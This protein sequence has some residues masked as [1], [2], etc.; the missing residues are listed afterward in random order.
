M[1]FYLIESEI[2]SIFLCISIEII[3]E[4]FEVA[5]DDGILY[6]GTC[7]PQYVENYKSILYSQYG[8]VQ[9]RRGF[10]FCTHAIAYTKWRA[11]RFWNDL[12]TSKLLHNEVGSD[13][14]SRAWQM[15]TKTYPFSVASNIQ[16]PPTTGHYGFFYQ[17]RGRHPSILQGWIA[18]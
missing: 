17:D 11:R 13:T 8:F 9:F 10:Y 14:I 16:W 5:K 4:G 15:I 3:E 2:L 6:L 18:G 7:G 1:K 12:A